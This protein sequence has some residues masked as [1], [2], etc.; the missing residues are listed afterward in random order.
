MNSYAGKQIKDLAPGTILTM[1][2]NG[3]ETN[4]IVIQHNYESELNGKGKTWMMRTTFLPDDMPWG[5]ENYYST[6]NWKD[7]TTLRSWLETT[8]AAR[9]SANFLSVIQPVSIHYEYGSFGHD[10]GTLEGQ[11]FWIPSKS[12]FLPDTD[13]ELAKSL[14]GW[15][16]NTLSEGKEDAKGGWSFTFATRSS[17]TTDPTDS[18]ESGCYI[19]NITMARFNSNYDPSTTSTISTAKSSGNVLVCFCVD[20]NAY[21]TDAGILTLNAPPVI[22]SNY[23]GKSGVFGRWDAFRLAY[24]AYDPEG[25]LVSVTEKLDGAVRKRFGNTNQNEIFHFEVSK[26]ELE[27]FDWNTY[28]TLTVEATDGVTTTI[29]TCKVFRVKLPGY[30][31][32]I[33]QI[34]GTGDG[35]SYYW[36]ERYILHDPAD[37]NAGVIL[38]PEVTLE[39]NQIGSFSFTVPVSNPYYDKL[40]LRKPVISVEED[41]REIFMGYAT[42]INKN[43]NLDLEVTCESELGYLQDRQCEVENKRYTTAELLE[44]ALA[45]EDDSTM[46]SGFKSEGKVFLPGNVTKLK[47]DDDEDKETKEIT[48]G[49]SIL[50]NSLVSKYGGYLRLRK[51]IKM[52][53][54][55]RV[56]TRYLD[57]IAKLDEKTDQTIELGKNLLD[58][59]YYIKA[60]DIVNSVKAVGWDTYQSGWFFWEKKTDR[61]TAEAYN[62]DS[63]KRYGLCQ[64]LLI[65]EGTNSTADSLLKKAK[66]E[67]AKYNG[68]TGSLTVN[69]ADLCDV[70]VDTDR[71]GFMKETYVL[72]EA[73]GID[74][75]LPC[76]KVVIPLDAPEEK[77]FTFGETTQKL[78]SLQAGNFATAGKAWN[79]I[80]STIGYM[81]SK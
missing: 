41:G 72:S 12:D 58:I 34:R 43:F 1:T 64:K 47:D 35:Q 15:F 5:T 14:R 32:Y 16:A 7:D 11:R 38:E 8:Y 76:T 52:V 63:I 39:A 25:A 73:H 13:T 81:S 17:Q 6:I 60:G 18:D 44:L 36:Q 56:Y 71:L 51:E 19:W 10:V 21:V 3:V 46:H 61:V 42:E 2:E 67:L 29:K 40:D 50:Q 22:E 77:E 70:G 26:E 75:W 37:E 79:A 53:Y 57:Y 62:G 80:Q 33:G 54:G 74:K 66:E 68:F 9:L 48:D 49:W 31:V 4:I 65:V 78:S 24:K 30:V 27:G 20:E 23:F 59:S 69:A 45:V 55:V 28:H